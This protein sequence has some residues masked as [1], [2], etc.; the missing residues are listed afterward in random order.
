MMTPN[1]LRAV[2]NFEGNLRVGQLVDVKWTAG[3]F[4][5][6][7]GAGKV[8]RVNRASVRVA[9]DAT[10]DTGRWGTYA[11]GHEIVVPLLADSGFKKWAHFNRVEPCGGYQ[12]AS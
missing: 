4:G 12:V 5:H 9:L 11:A 2:T 3:S 7:E 6:Y 1:E 10:V 8:V